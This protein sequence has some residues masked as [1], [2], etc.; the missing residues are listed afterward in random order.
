MYEAAII[1]LKIS[2]ETCENNAPIYE[3]DGDAAQAAH[4]RANAES[5]RAAIELLRN[6]GI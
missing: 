5:Y 3:A 1:Q 6:Y 4:T 2:A